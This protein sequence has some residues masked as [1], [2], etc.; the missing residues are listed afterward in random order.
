MPPACLP[1]RP[2]QQIR[3]IKRY[4]CLPGRRI[5]FISIVDFRRPIIGRRWPAPTPIA[6][7]T[8]RIAPRARHVP[9]PLPEPLPLPGPLPLHLRGAPQPL[10]PPRPRRAPSAT[11]APRRAPECALCQGHPQDARCLGL[12]SRESGGGIAPP[13]GPSIYAAGALCRQ[14][15]AVRPLL[16]LSAATQRCDHGTD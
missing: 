9:R 1:G 10:G 3:T 16:R 8:T 7:R 14:Y 5:T 6:P 13:T 15:R 4:R 2:V 12:T 11:Q